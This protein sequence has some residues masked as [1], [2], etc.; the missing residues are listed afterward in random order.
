MDVSSNCGVPLVRRAFDLVRLAVVLSSGLVSVSNGSVGP[1]CVGDCD[2]SG[3]VTVDELVK[4]VSIA[5]GTLPVDQCPR[6]DCSSP[7]PGSLSLRGA[8]W[9]PPTDSSTPPPLSRWI[10]TAPCW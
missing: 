2:N 6:F 9:G 3:A 4:G 10:R 7:K 5:L 8:A 1:T